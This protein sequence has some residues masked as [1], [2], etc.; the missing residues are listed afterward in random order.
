MSQ[1][2]FKEF[3]LLMQ[4][5]KI[6]VPPAALQDIVEAIMKLQNPDLTVAHQVVYDLTARIHDD[7]EHAPPLLAR[8]FTLPGFLP[9]AVALA[10][11]TTAATWLL[12][13]VSHDARRVPALVQAGAIEPLVATLH[14]E[15]G[16]AWPQVGRL[17]NT[18]VYYC[19]VCYFIC[20]CEGGRYRTV[21]KPL[22]ETLRP[23]PGESWP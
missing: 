23:H 19:Y 8:L 2:P 4:H 17:V 22:V 5:S 9:T 6:A 11:Y 16:E 13:Y 10:R 15:P 21:M 18:F 20:F 7:P 1:P 3:N 14:P 12:Y